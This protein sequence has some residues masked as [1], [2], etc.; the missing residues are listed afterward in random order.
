MALQ[1]SLRCGLATVFLSILATAALG[2]ESSLRSASPG[3]GTLSLDGVAM[4]NLTWPVLGDVVPAANIVRAGDGWQR[5]ELT[6]EVPTPIQQDEL[7]VAFQWLFRPDFHWLPH[8]APSD[9]FVV[10]QHVFRSPAMIAV[11]GAQQQVLAV[12]PDLDLVGQRSDAPWF[13]DLDARH[14]R[15]WLGMT[16]TDIPVHVGF[17]KRPGMVIEPG[18]LKLAFYIC[19]YRDES[20]PLNPWHKVASLL[21]ERYARPLYEQGQP[22]TAP[23]DVYVKHTY[24]WAF[25]IDSIAT[26]KLTGGVSLTDLAGTAQ[27]Q[28]RV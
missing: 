22:G 10:G 28:G 16:L 2:G 3:T 25:G 6:W 4:A 23:L 8:L 26:E 1:H 24:N 5:V 15:A 13:M 20:T 17:R 18:T 14:Q 19:A 7:A 9:G 11:N 21:W 27:D 12:V